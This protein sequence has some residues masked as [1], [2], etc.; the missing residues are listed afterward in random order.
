MFVQF[1]EAARIA[2]VTEHQ[3]KEWCMRRSLITPDVQARGRGRNALFGW[4]A[5]LALRMLSVI[6]SRFG[7]TVAHWGPILEDFRC[8]IEINSFPALFGQMAVFDGHKVQLRQ[9]ID[10]GQS[11]ALFIKLD[12][13]LLAISRGLGSNDRELQLP[14]FPPL[15]V[16]R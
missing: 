12:D 7:G 16:T 4:R 6:H 9:S 10:Q 1:A 5:L 15:L 11:E 3:L 2:G 13:H 14:L 8:S